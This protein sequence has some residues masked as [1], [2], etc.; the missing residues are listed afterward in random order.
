MDKSKT[1]C[2]TGH[3]PAGLP[4]HTDETALDCLY[5]KRLMADVLAALYDVGNRHFL[6]GMAVGADL[7][8]AEAVLALQQEHPDVTLE[9]AIPFPDQASRWRLETRQRYETLLAACDK[10]TVI[11]P[12]HTATCMMERNRYMV[13]CSHLLLAVYNHQPGGTRNTI[14]YA[15]QQ[16]LEVVLLPLAPGL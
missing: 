13:D 2:F 9:A 1:C 12:Q 6:C 5:L 14:R 8:F 7:Y 3:R 16:G 4:W 10:R 11:S 15:R